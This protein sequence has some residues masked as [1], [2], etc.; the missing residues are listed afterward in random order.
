[1]FYESE[2]LMEVLVK[3]SQKIHKECD[4]FYLKNYK[5]YYR[6][7]KNKPTIFISYEHDINEKY[8]CDSDYIYVKDT[9]DVIHNLFE[10]QKHR[11]TRK[12]L[13]QKYNIDFEN[14]HEYQLDD[15]FLTIC[16][17]CDILSNKYNEYSDEDYNNC[18]D[19]IEYK[20]YDYC[21][22]CEIKIPE[23]HL[24]IC[25]YCERTRCLPCSW[26]CHKDDACIMECG[27][28]E[29]YHCFGGLFDFP[30]CKTSKAND[31]HIDRC[32]DMF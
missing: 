10:Y 30:R 31:D 22:C 26:G 20:H 29:K 23:Q 27:S 8:G 14:F 4:C 11:I 2:E 25:Y 7:N 15:D 16:I 18:K 5:P 6:I 1:M 32:G 28:C 21:E 19:Y 3:Q 9:N 17:I 13:L 24:I 12:K